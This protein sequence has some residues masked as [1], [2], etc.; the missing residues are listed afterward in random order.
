[1][2]VPRSGEFLV[3]L[4]LAPKSR[5]SLPR[6]PLSRH[7]A[8]LSLGERIPLTN[9]TE[10]RAR[11]LGELHLALVE[12]YAPPSVI[13]D[14][15]NRILHLSP[16]AGRMLQFGAGEPSQNLLKVVHPG[17]R[18]ESRTALFRAAQSNENITIAQVTIE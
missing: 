1:R 11:A 7:I 13:V 12:Q 17:L 14:E 9:P 4:P 2:T 18:V 16:H 8:P 5:R 10:D 6:A 3:S 15:N